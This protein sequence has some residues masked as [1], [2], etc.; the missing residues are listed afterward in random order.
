VPQQVFHTPALAVSR[1]HSLILVP[2]TMPS[3][4]VCTNQYRQPHTNPLLLPPP[5]TPCVPLNR[6]GERA[7]GYGP[8]EASL[9]EEG[10]EEGLSSGLALLAHALV[11]VAGQLG[12]RLHPFACGPVSAAIGVCVPGERALEG[13][14]QQAGL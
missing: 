5:T 2:Y 9:H 6:S 10:E 12:V 7:A 13:G 8:A 4:P 11:D 1:H 14:A 3:A